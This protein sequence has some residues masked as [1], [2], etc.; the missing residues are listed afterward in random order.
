[1]TRKMS[2]AFWAAFSAGAALA[3]APEIVADS[4]SLSK[5]AAEMVKIGYTLT[6]APAVV[7]VDI[8]TN[9][10]AGGTGEWVSIGGEG[11]GMLGGE[12][13]KVVYALDVPVAAYWFPAVAFRDQAV[14]A[15]G[16][17]A[18]V[19]AWPTNCPPDYMTVDLT[20]PTGTAWAVRRY[21]A[22]TNALPGGFANPAY[23]TTHLLMRKI[24][25]AGVVWKMGAPTT[26]SYYRAWDM[27]HKVMLTEDYYAA[28]YETTQAQY[29]NINGALGS[30]AFTKYADSGIRPFQ[31]AMCQQLR[32]MNNSTMAYYWPENGHTVAVDSVIGKLRRKCGI[33][34]IDLP[35]EAQWEYACRAGSGTA[36]YNGL[37]Y[38]G[39]NL[40]IVAW[41]T[42]NATDTA[43]IAATGASETKKM[44][45]VVGTK[46]PNAW[47][48]YDMLGNV[49]EFCLD[50]FDG[51]SD[52][53]TGI[54]AKVKAYTDTFEPGWDDAESPS[55]TTNPVGIATVSVVSVVKRGGA[56]MDNNHRIRCAARTSAGINYTDGNGNGY[57]GFR[58]F[59][60]VREAVK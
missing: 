2:I 10:A 11:M 17:R 28:V 38:S 8:Q 36:L 52:D 3:A 55:V 44:P 15:G 29:G 34:D 23:K 24:P 32:G 30:C 45:H 6:G 51:R 31:Q 7:T 21:Y 46:Q 20:A 57:I 19:K 48:L 4:V 18:E 13:N 33:A 1:M 5:G 53:T 50:R 56:W 43:V 40:D 27:Q 22:G 35:T 26:E 60:S 12:A 49:F 47:G 58:L 16:L 37:D 59:C 41:R 54:D 14:A 42:D 9:T 39:A 25:A